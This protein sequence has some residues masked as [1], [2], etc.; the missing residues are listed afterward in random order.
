MVEVVIGAVAVQGGLEVAAAA[1]GRRWLYM[2]DRRGPRRNEGARMKSEPAK[3][4]RARTNRRNG[5]DGAT[6]EDWGLGMDGV[7][8]CVLLCS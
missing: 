6:L 1:V 8:G 3:M 5:D 7:W 2:D 4:T